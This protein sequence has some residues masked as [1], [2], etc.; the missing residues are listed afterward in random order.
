[1]VEPNIEDIVPEELDTNLDMQYDF[2]MLEDEV[3]H[4]VEPLDEIHHG[5]RDV[6]PSPTPVLNEE[7]PQV[8]NPYEVHD[9]VLLAEKFLQLHCDLFVPKIL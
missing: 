3:S 1:M 2:G 4:E 5:I 9:K 7:I 6:A 8:R